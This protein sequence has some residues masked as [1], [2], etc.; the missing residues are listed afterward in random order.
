MLVWFAATLLPPLPAG[1]EDIYERSRR[2]FRSCIYNGLGTF[3]PEH[4][5]RCQRT[6][7]VQGRIHLKV[8]IT[9]FKTIKI[10]VFRPDLATKT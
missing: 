3:A 6:L 7:D 2:L 10:F 8:E 5:V 9:V 4:Y 1:S